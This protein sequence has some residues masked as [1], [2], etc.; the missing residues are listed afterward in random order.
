[1]NGPSDPRRDE[2]RGPVSDPARARPSDTQPGAAGPAV[3]RVL[4]LQRAAGNHAVARMLAATQ[5]PQRSV[6]NLPR[7]GR[8]LQRDIAQ[9]MPTSQGVFDINMIARNDALTGT[10]TGRTG[11]DGSISFMPDEKSPYTSKLAMLQIIKYQDGA[12]SDINIGSMPAA[13]GPH[14]RTTEDTTAGVE[15]GWATDAMHQNF[16]PT[17]PVPATKGQEHTP[18]YEGGAPQFGFRRSEKAADIKAAMIT[19]FP[20]T[21]SKTAERNIAFETVAKG[22]DNQVVYGAVQWAFKIRAGK[23]QD[24]TSSVSDTGSANYDAAL[25]RHREYYVHEPVTIYFDFDGDAPSAGEAPKFDALLPYLAKFPDVRIKSEGFADLRGASPHNLALAGRRAQ[26]CIDELVT[27][28]IDA[29]RFAAPAATGITT[30]FAA[31]AVT[32]QADEANRRANR[33]VMLTFER[34]ASTP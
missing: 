4:A 23:V 33:R 19:D 15:A 17:P 9:S 1:M 3:E 12:G 13:A 25:E 21:T 22:D 18:Y 30:S 8:L 31:D 5:R 27:R 26:K 20:G 16:N 14:L 11:L 7:R 24:E 10:G 34:T 6:A 29:T 28:G 2:L 32:P